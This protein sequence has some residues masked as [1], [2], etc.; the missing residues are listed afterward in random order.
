MMEPPQK[1]KSGA[2]IIARSDT[3][4]LA[5]GEKNKLLTKV[6]NACD[7]NFGRIAGGIS[8]LGS[9]GMPGPGEVPRRGC[10]LSS[11]GNAAPF[12]KA[13]GPGPETERLA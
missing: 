12:R 5:T 4:H 1:P 8:F 11:E 9:S 3:K 2:L 13:S 7:G 6:R 10:L